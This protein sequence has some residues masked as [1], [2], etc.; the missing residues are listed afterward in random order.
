MGYLPFLERYTG[1]TKLPNPPYKPQIDD[2][3]IRVRPRSVH[4]YESG[5]RLIVSYL[6]HGIMYDML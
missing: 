6:N 2:G 4:F 1:A 3:D 5:K